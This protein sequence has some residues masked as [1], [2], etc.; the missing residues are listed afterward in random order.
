MTSHNKRNEYKKM[1]MTNIVLFSVIVGR[2]LAKEIGG[3]LKVDNLLKGDSHR[4]FSDVRDEEDM[5]EK[6]IGDELIA[7]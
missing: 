2:T 5:N 3:P 1:S 4:Q 7:A 6:A